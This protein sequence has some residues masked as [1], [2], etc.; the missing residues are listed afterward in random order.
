VRQWPAA[1]C[2]VGG[3]KVCLQCDETRGA[4]TL[5]H[6]TRAASAGARRGA[7][8]RPAD[9][10]RLVRATQGTRR[11]GAWALEGVLRWEGARVGADGEASRP[12]AGAAGARQ[13]GTG[14]RGAARHA[15]SR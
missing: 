10:A 8:G 15:S 6:R 2:F 12:G 7:R 1:A 13:R 11:L 5:V 3:G 9:H 4:S 14:A